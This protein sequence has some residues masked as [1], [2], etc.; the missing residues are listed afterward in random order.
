MARRGWTREGAFRRGA[1]RGGWEALELELVDEPLQ[2]LHGVLHEHA[3]RAGR[4][5]RPPTRC[6]DG[7][8]LAARP[9][10]PSRRVTS[11][12]YALPNMGLVQVLLD[13]RV[14]PVSIRRAN[15]Q[16]VGRP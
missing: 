16:A 15:L 3:A 13:G 7:T 9:C 11:P 6:C 2:L 1:L 12:G 4:L 10:V 14:T 5:W 8:V